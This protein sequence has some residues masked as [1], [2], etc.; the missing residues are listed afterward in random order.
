M[1]GASM[2]ETIMSDYDVRLF[3][4]KYTVWKSERAAGLSESKAFERFVVEQILKDYDLDNDETEAGDIGGGDDGGVDA[5]YLFMNGKLISEDVPPIIP[6]GPIELHIIQAKEETSF[7]EVPVTKLEAFAKDMLSY[8]KPVDEMTYLNSNAQDA[9]ANFREKYDDEVMGHPHTLAVHFHYACKADALPGSKDK[10]NVRGG[11]LVKYVRSILSSAD[12]SFTLWNAKTLHDAVKTPMESIIVLPVIESFSTKDGSTVCIV[13][14]TDYAER[15]LTKE[16]GELQTRF[17]EPNVRDYM[18]LKNPVNTQIRTTLSTPIATEEFWWLNNGITILAEE[19][20]VDGKKAK[21]KN[22]EIVNG[23]QTSHEVYQWKKTQN[24]NADDRAILVKIIVA[25]DEKTRSRVIKS[26]NSQ[27]A[28][29]DLSLMANDPIQESIEDRLRLYGLYYDRK[30]GEYRRLKKPIKSLVG[31]GSLAQAFMAVVLQKPDQA[32]GRP[33]TYV[34]NNKN[35]VYDDNI[36]LDFYAA[37][38][39]IDRQIGSYLDALRTAGN[40]SWN[41]T[42]NLR[43]YVAMLIGMKWNLASKLAKSVQ[44]AMKE[45]IKPLQPDEVQDAIARA[46]KVYET[47]GSNDTAAKSSEMTSK[48]LAA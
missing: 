30:K 48:V 19:C 22:P 23:L 3:E 17:L 11:N 18:G 16:N 46:K 44:D 7:K 12:V 8:D 31:M 13:K 43:Y 33:A 47:L 24:S 32:R 37:S 21:I 2:I 14:L 4:A 29:S 20:P 34:K 42:R 25:T 28:V 45:L 6:A 10:I 26:T 38:I 36:D 15:L 41:D 5:M 35:V 40:L 39:L 27:T 9:I 1:I